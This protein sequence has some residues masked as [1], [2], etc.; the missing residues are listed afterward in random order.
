MAKSKFFEEIKSSVIEREVEDV[1]NNGI[2]LYFPNVD[3]KHP[4]A[5]DGLIETKTDEGKILKLII[6]YKFNE[7]LATPSARAKI[8]VQVLYYLKRFENEGLILPNVCL[9]GDK[10]ECFV[11]HTN[12]IQKYLDEDV[13]W[14]IAP[15]KAHMCNGDLVLKITNDEN[16]NPFIFDID[17]NFSFKNVYEKIISLTENIQRYV[18][19]TEHNIA[20]IF[21]Y[22]ITKVIKDKKKISP[23]ELVSIFIGVITDKENY[24]L[25]PSK[26]NTLISNGKEVKID[27]RSFKSFFSYFD[28]NY[29]PKEKN[30]FS[31]ISDRLIEDT[32]R[33]NKGEFYTPTLYVDYAHRMIESELGENWKNEYVVWDASA[34]SKNLTRDYYFKEL[35]SSTLE[36][37]ELEI[38]KRYNPEAVSFQ[39]D[40]LNDGLEK[41]PKGLI[42]AFE[43]NKPILFFN[44]PPYATAGIRNE[45][46]KEGV[47]KTKVNSQMLKDNI[48]A[49]SQNLYAQFLYRI[50]QI[51]KMYNLTNCHIALFSPSLFLSGSSYKKFRSIFL[52]EFEYK[53]AFLMCASEFAD[54]ANNWGI[55]FT[56]WNNGITND[57][58]NFK[59]NVVTKGENGE[60]EIIQNKVIYNID[61]T[62]SASE[63]AKELIKKYKTFED[64]NL[65]SALTIRDKNSRGRNFINNLGY[66]YNDSNNIDKNAMSVSLFSTSFGN[67][68]GHGISK[69]NFIHCTSL[70]SARKLIEANWINSKDEYLA[71]NE[72]HEKWQEFVNDSIVY[73][74]FN[75]SSNQSSLRNITY[76]GKQYDI[77]NE[78]FFMS[79]KEIEELSEKNNLDY[80]YQ[81]AHTM[82][83]RYVYTILKGIELSKE[84]RNVLDKAIELTHKTFKYRLLFNDE[85]PEYQILNAD[86]GWYQLRALIKEYI[87]NELKEF[88]KLYKD[89]SDKMRPMVYELGFLKL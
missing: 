48:G 59:M 15:S 1:Y 38:G 33:R 8:L 62:K 12:D 3:I 24:Y 16:I 29:T 57:K 14:N 64:V 87:P 71:P 72:Q 42:K 66:F 25:H 63:W 84:A 79:K 67:G 68:N 10:N 47:A 82:S 61:S 46:S 53:N 27:S 78:F 28:H 81:D 2:T 41:L 55:N 6:E 73:S 58:E 89:L 50:I 21:D 51:K 88:Q 70:F 52:N 17:E 31:E 36:E 37:S 39:Y 43:E 19:I 30:R 9:V 45:K 18:R 7:N 69:D 54:C 34:G 26:T 86:C 65:K 23:N 74:L 76:K 35:Y 60:I 32:N 22:F 80:T 77:K 13:D 49:C 4:F 11:I 5:C 20:T 83:E 44:N 85:H 75:S 56:F 40:F